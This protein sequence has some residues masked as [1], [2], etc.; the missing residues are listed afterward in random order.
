[1]MQE[2]SE[3]PNVLFEPEPPLSVLLVEDNDE[4]A[5]FLQITLSRVKNPPF[6]LE[7]TG[8]LKETL[9]RL[10]R[11][12]ADLVILDLSLPDCRGFS[13]FQAVKE[14]D[15]RAS[16]VVLTGYN[17]ER[18]A[19][20]ALNMGAQDYIVKGNLDTS[21]LSRSMRFAVE[22]KRAEIALLESEERFRAVIDHALDTITTINDDGTILSFNAAGE[23]TFGYLSREVIG[24]NIRILIPEFPL[25]ARGS[26][27]TSALTTGAS[28]S[29]THLVEMRGR[30]KQGHTIY[31]EISLS[32]SYQNGRP[33]LVGVSRKA[34]IGGI[35][36]V[37]VNDRLYGS[38]ALATLAVWQGVAIVRSHDV[39]PTVDAVRICHAVR[40]ESPGVPL[41]E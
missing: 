12:G 1:M 31:L 5:E 19:L 10:D 22:R 7:R 15:S 39:R 18:L 4:D 25:D 13:T 35:L 32:Q 30:H 14:K 29:H 26:G 24:R 9:E 33:L 3:I 28:P 40:R 41:Y 11:G 38:L 16:I 20:K 36:D 6:H 34:M 17:D 37:P 2:L 23:K 21:H 8:T 27:L